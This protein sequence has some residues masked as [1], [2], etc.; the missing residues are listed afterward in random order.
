MI[1]YLLPFGHR[2]HAAL[3]QGQDS[4]EMMIFLHLRARVGETIFCR[5]SYEFQLLIMIDGWLRKL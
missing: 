3:N 4:Q 2:C 5:G 1:I